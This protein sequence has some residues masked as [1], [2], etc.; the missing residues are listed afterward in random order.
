[1]AGKFRGDGTHKVDAKGRVSIPAAF[2]H[3]LAQNDPECGHD[4]NPNLIMVYG[5]RSR[6]F[7]EVYSI[8]AMADI[9][10]KIDKLPRGSKHRRILER[11]FYG[12]AMQVQVDDTGRLVLPPK[13]REK[14]GIA[15]DAF[16]IASGDT[17]Q[18]W[19]PEVYDGDSDRFEEFFDDLDDDFDVLSLLEPEVEA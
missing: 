12:Q 7:L 19:A 9:D 5:G 11:T 16:F 18:I 10:T 6:K 8:E 13:L 3:V 14:V 17:F 1:V 2:R 4:D 15:K